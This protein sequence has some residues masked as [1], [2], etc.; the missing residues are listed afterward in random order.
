M[1]G[2]ITPEELFAVMFAGG[3]LNDERS[4][5]M[6]ESAYCDPAKSIR[7]ASEIERARLE[8]EKRKKENGDH[9]ELPCAK[10]K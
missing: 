4:C 7:F 1:N 9:M 5:A 8:K 3:R 6:Q 2:D 10:N